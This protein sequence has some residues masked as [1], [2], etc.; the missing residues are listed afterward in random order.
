MKALSFRNLIIALVFSPVVCS[1]GGVSWE[2]L[3]KEISKYQ[4]KI[5]QN[6]N[7]C[8]SLSQLGSI[9]QYRREYYQAIELYD[10]AYSI[11]GNL[12]DLFQ[13]SFTYYVVGDYE[14][15]RKLAKQAINLASEQGDKDLE[16]MFLK[17]FEY[18]ES[19]IQLL[20]PEQTR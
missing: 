4:E 3:S 11:C 13:I 2:N 20:T 7:D 14:K 8:F 12:L 5:E 10:R 6:P 17:E 1:A 9:R 19:Q 15:G 18:L 16:S